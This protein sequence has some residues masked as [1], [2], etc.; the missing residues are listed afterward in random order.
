M[1]LLSR[2]TGPAVL[3]IHGMPTNGELWTDIIDRLCHQFTCYTIDLPGLGKTPRESYGSDYLQSLAERIEALRIANRVEKWHVVGHDAG[4]A[5][6]AH[7]T[8]SFQQYVGRLVLLSPALFPELRPYFLL[9]LL[10]KPILGELLAPAITS[11]F[12]N[13]PMRL[14]TRNEEGMSNPGFRR[15][16]R[17]FN[18]LEGSWRL[19][20]VMRWGK[21]AKLLAR[22][23]VCL[24]RLRVPTLILHGSRDVAIPG[25]FATR[26]CSLI[27]NAQLIQIDCGHFIPLNRPLLV[28]SHLVQF[29]G[30]GSCVSSANKWE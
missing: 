10:R 27:P 4:S 18:G 28:A 13:V 12:W 29:L 9:E 8:E 22:M 2:G 26:A 14:A 20:R 1:Y 16:R 24:P 3:F 25:T 6:A 21:P 15:F 30:A 7:Y 11:L 23:P 5:I 17:P 19:M